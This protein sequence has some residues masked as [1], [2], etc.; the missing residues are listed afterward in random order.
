MNDGYSNIINII[1]LIFNRY[2]GKH[3][4]KDKNF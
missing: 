3:T 2:L 1:I 4:N